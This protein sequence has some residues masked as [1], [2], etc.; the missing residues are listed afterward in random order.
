MEH[1][2]KLPGLPELD[3][4]RALGELCKRRFYRFFLEMWETIEAAELVPNWHIEYICDELQDVYERWAR[5]EAQDDVLINVPP[6]STKSTIVT[7]LFPAWLWV[8]SAAIRAIS[9]SYAGDLAT[10]HAVKT[11]DCLK[12][13]KFQAMYGKDFIK[14][15]ED[16]DGKTHYKNTAKGERFVTSTGGRVTGMHGDFILIDDPINPEQ[17]TGEAE[18]KKATRFVSRTLATRKT[19]KKR[20]VTIM[21]MQRLHEADPA[22]EWRKKKKLRYICLP[23][24]LSKDVHPA[25]LKDRYIDGL[26]DVRRL[27]REALDKLKVDLG[28]YG[29]AGQIQQR[30][31]PEDGGIWKQWFIPIPDNAFPERDQLEDYG[32]DWDT[33]YTEDQKND[34]SAFCTSGCIR[35]KEGKKIFIDKLGHAKKE[36]PDLIRLMK[37]M[38]APHYIEAKASGKSAKQTL[39]SNGIPAIEVQVVGGDKIARTKMATPPVE[40]GLVYIRQSL[41]EALYNDAEQGI[42]VFPNGL[43]DD[44]NDAVVQAIQRHTQAQKE[45]M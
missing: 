43:H 37:A 41:V 15:K 2:K 4:W 9:S 16:T 40:A 45:W 1:L 19:D 23:G 25:E 11:R 32:T 17:A 26:L 35:L 27:P 30:P 39:V 34:A 42:L 18:L 12:S 38:P 24:E 13:E 14:F 22:G 5:G 33:A 8:K 28:S 6:G 10:A 7:Q 21:V 20:S 29:Y 31:A 3:P 44:V 36:F